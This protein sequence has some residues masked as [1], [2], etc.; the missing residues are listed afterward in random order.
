MALKKVKCLRCGHKW[1]PRVEGRPKACPACKSYR[2]N[3]PPQPPG[4]PPKKGK[5]QY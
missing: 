1:T 2:W 4:R 5:G 3:K